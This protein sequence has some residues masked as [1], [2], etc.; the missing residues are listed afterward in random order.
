MSVRP[1][2]RAPARAPASVGAPVY[3]SLHGPCIDLKPGV[4]LPPSAPTGTIT[5]GFAN[6]V[7]EATK[8]SKERITYDQAAR[9]MFD[10]ISK[11]SWFSDMSK[12]Y[13]KRKRE[14]FAKYVEEQASKVFGGLSKANALAPLQNR[15]NQ[16]PDVGD[17][18]KQ[19]RELTVLEGLIQLVYKI[20]EKKQKL[21]KYSDELRSALVAEKW[22]EKRLQDTKQRVAAA[23]NAKQQLIEQLKKLETNRTYITEHDLYDDM[24]V[25]NPQDTIQQAL[26]ENAHPL[27]DD[28]L[29]EAGEAHADWATQRAREEHQRFESR[30][31][32]GNLPPLPSIYR[33]AIDL[34]KEQNRVAP[35][36]P[37]PSR[38]E[39]RAE[40][41][42]LL[43]AGMLQGDWAEQMVR[44]EREAKEEAKGVS[45]DQ[46]AAHSDALRAKELRELMDELL[47]DEEEEDS[48]DEDGLPCPKH[49]NPAASDIGEN[50]KLAMA[51]A[52]NGAKWKPIP[53]VLGDNWG[54]AGW[55]D[56]EV[57]EERTVARFPLGNGE[58]EYYTAIK[59][60]AGIVLDFKKVPLLP[61]PETLE[62][63]APRTSSPGE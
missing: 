25:Q 55:W 13:R 46:Y 43:A 30:R 19:Y 61:Q 56:Y 52:I 26:D 6:L 14:E 11:G 2:S 12:E 16:L 60:R 41:K 44:A 51:A 4:P 29:A 49:E 34:R 59:D 1:R 62:E 63:G 48:C 7:E 32:A 58:Y 57:N 38:A 36:A 40:A 5:E 28:E 8:W 18:A 22:R 20:I 27:A 24:Q 50:L 23:Q 42:R 15:K 45:D 33:L 10:Q 9:D 21:Q 39:K 35:Y 37:E 47:R 54:V 17:Y 3:G 53:E 31:Q